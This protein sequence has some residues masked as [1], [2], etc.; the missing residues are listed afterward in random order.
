MTPPSRAEFGAVEVSISIVLF[1][2][3]RDHKKG[4]AS[5]GT[6]S[7]VLYLSPAKK[8]GRDDGH[9]SRT[10]IAQNLKRP[11]PSRLCPCLHGQGKFEWAI[12]TPLWNRRSRHST[13]GSGTYLVLLRVGFT[14]LPQS[15]RVL[16]SSYLTF[17][18]LPCGIGVA[19]IPQGGIFSV[20]LSLP[21]PVK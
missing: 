1:Q 5:K 15:L 8:R 13:G 7:R 16:V 3:P 18:P 4:G 17:S 19:A 2:L 14:K 21:R 11:N 9:L 12:L 10:L 6:I 20:A